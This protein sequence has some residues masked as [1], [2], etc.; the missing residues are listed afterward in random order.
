MVS[1]QNDTVIATFKTKGAELCSLQLKA[2]NLEYI[3]QAGEEW[4]KYSPILFPIVGSL[5]DGHYAYQG[6]KYN[7]NRHGFA[8]DAFFKIVSQQSDAIVFEWQSNDATRQYYPFDFVLQVSY[9]VVDNSLSIAYTV[10]N[11]G[12]DVMYFSIGGH[13]AFKV[14]LEEGYAF[15]DYKLSFDFGSEQVFPINIYPL[16]SDGLTQPT[17]IPYFNDNNCKIPLQQSLFEKD[18]LVFKGIN[19]AT[20]SIE[21]AASERSLQLTYTDFSYLGIWNKHGADFVCIEPWCGITDSTHSMHDFINKEGI[22]MLA[23]HQSW[24]NIYIIHIN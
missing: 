23:G 9:K 19:N 21:N 22:I 4:P 14:P 13:P 8:R 5:K 1:I 11:T 6:T 16:T 17:G 24:K 3:W 7:L 12:N 20:I 10:K 2:Y 18:A 15:E